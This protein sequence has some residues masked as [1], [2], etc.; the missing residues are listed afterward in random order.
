MSLIIPPDL[1]NLSNAKIA[2]RLGCTPTAVMYARRRA[3]GLC[4]RCK[5]PVAP[6]GSTVCEACESAID[7]KRR[8]RL[9]HNPWKPGGKGRPPKFRAPA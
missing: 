4:E 6:G 7:L 5:A 1:A 3:A 2:T 9:G 8:K